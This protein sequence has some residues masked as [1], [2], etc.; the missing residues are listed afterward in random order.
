MKIIELRRSLLGSKDYSIDGV[1]LA[2]DNSRHDWIC[3]EDIYKFMKNYGFDADFRQIEKLVEVL[4]YK[5][6]GKLTKE[7]LKWT[8]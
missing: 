3:T 2:I 7:Q 8:V 6:N 5:L 4:N 1:L